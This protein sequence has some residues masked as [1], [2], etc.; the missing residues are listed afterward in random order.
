M[1]KT[2]DNAI[3]E[4][5]QEDEDGE[6][7]Q[8]PDRRFE[9]DEK[10]EETHEH[11]RRD[12][13]EQILDEVTAREVVGSDFIAGEQLVVGQRVVVGQQDEGLARRHHRGGEEN[14]A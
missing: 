2:S 11:D 12:G 5:V 3:T 8:I 7:L 10:K 4:G 13:D 9:E 1:K 6:G 14:R